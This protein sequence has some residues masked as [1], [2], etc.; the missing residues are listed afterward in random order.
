MAPARN[1]PA[2]RLPCAGRT[3]GEATRFDKPRGRRRVTRPPEHG[4]R[5]LRPRW[6][7]RSSDASMG[8]QRKQ[9]MRVVLLGNS[10]ACKE[11]ALKRR[12]Q[13]VLDFIRHGWFAD[14]QV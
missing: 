4:K 2:P 7:N 1:H 13:V 3:D 10:D 9:T 11:A 6:P 8:S 14:P 5:L 12:K